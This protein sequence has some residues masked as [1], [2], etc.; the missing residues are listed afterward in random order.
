MDK[1]STIST[2]A[3]AAPKKNA[4]MK[5]AMDINVNS[6]RINTI[7]CI[8]LLLLHMRRGWVS[9]YK[10]SGRPMGLSIDFKFI[11]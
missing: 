4:P 1:P 2:T 6:T 10:P 11:F 3:P 7:S 5:P 9:V 8:W